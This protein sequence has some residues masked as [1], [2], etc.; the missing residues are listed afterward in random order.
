MSAF[1]QP[2]TAVVRLRG[3]AVDPVNVIWEFI[4]LFWWFLWALYLGR[5]S[6]RQAFLAASQHGE[7]AGTS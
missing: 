4:G 2:G 7:G 5:K 6:T 1:A 3:F